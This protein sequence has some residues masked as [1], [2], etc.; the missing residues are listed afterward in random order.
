MISLRNV[1][2]NSYK[3]IILSVLTFGIGFLFVTYRLLKERNNHFKEQYNACLLLAQTMGLWLGVEALRSLRRLTS[4]TI[5][6]NEKLWLGALVMSFILFYPLGLILL[7][8]L[9]YVLAMDIIMHIDYELIMF[10]KLA[11]FAGVSLQELNLSRDNPRRHKRLLLISLV[12]LI[13][14]VGS[15]VLYFYIGYLSIAYDVP[16]IF[17]LLVLCLSMIFLGSSLIIEALWWD[18]ILSLYENH[19]HVSKKIIEKIL[20]IIV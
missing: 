9:Q 20:Q 11:S 16:F 5:L 12:L 7:S 14:F 4:S 15:L 6:R 8:L 2:S 1:L 19:I 18:R 10:E 13:L 17:T 3:W